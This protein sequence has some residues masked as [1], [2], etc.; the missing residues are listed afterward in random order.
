MGGSDKQVIECHFTVEASDLTA[1]A[2]GSQ[3]IACP[4]VSAD[5]PE[6]DASGEQFAVQLVQHVRSG[7]INKGRRREIAD[8]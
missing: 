2:V 1:Y 8:H 7:E 3:K 4:P 5:Y 6:R